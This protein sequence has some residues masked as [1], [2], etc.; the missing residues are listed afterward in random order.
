MR[1]HE[2]SELDLSDIILL[3]PVRRA[4]AMIADVAQAH[5]GHVCIETRTWRCSRQ[6]TSLCLYIYNYINLYIWIYTYIYTYMCV[7]IS[8]DFYI[9]I[10]L[11]RHTYICIC[12]CV[13]VYTYIYI[14]IYIRAYICIYIWACIIWSTCHKIQDL[15]QVRS[16]CSVMVYKYIYIYT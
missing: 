15:R 11:Y 3:L 9:F 7:C 8:I 6:Y 12:I 1:R 16:M 13:R 14:Y 4:V 10:C 5:L 2:L